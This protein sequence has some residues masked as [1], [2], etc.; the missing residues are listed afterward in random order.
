MVLRTHLAGDFHFLW[1]CLRVIFSMYWGSPS[2]VGSLC[3]LREV[4]RRVQVDKGVKLF[5]VGDEF[6]LHVFK[7]HFK[8]SILL[9]LNVHTTSDSVSHQLSKAWLHDMAEKIVS[10]ILVPSSSSDPVHDFHRSF[11]HH[12]FVYIDLRE[13]IRWEN[14]PQVIAHWKWWLPRFLA[15]GCRNYASESV[16]L[17]A[18]LKADFPRHIS[19]IA[20]HNRTVNT[21]GIAGRGKP[22]DQFIEHYNL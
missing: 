13:A 4:I 8:A 18:N 17:I 11:L 1:E 2:Q 5:N 14:G 16:K 10:D 3:N 12:M 20:T 21:S 15:T 22:V 6:L 7:S 9:I 19:Y